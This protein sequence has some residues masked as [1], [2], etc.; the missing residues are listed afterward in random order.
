MN[1]SNT[2]TKLLHILITLNTV[3]F[4]LLSFLHFYWAFG[5]TLWYGDVLPT[6]STGTKR[7]Q[8]GV[9][10]SFTVAFSL[11]SFALI[12]IGN[13]GI[14]YKHIKRKYFSYGALL[15][16][17]IFFI[18]AIGDFKFIGFFKTVNKTRFALND[19]QLFSPICLFIAIVSLWIFIAT[20]HKR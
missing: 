2:S 19:T 9:M 7:M 10:A 6:N 11:L 15:I 4:L 5:G 17:I 18:R 1:D 3:I 16:S 12:T 8:P 13:H 20:K 14:W